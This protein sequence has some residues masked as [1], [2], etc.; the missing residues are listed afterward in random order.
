MHIIKLYITWC[1]YL[2]KYNYTKLLT[3]HLM[4]LDMLYDS[5]GDKILFSNSRQKKHFVALCK[6]L[7][8]FRVIFQK[9]NKK[10]WWLSVIWDY[11]CIVRL[12]F[13]LYV[14][15]NQEMDCKDTI[16]LHF[17]TR[18]E[19]ITQRFFSFF[20]FCNLSCYFYLLTPYYPSLKITSQIHT[21]SARWTWMWV[22]LQHQITL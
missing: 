3:Q 16:L 2:W 5:T 21:Q 6:L 7:K 12:I 18:W 10:T 20:F 17:P 1:I 22:A 11:K 15:L 4:N 8:P 19:F 13:L 14:A 9:L